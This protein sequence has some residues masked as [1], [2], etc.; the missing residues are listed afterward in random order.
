MK[1]V[2][3]DE[4]SRLEALSEKNGVTTAELMQKAGKS[5][6]S[7][8]KD[9]IE[10]N[11]FQKRVYLLVGKGNNGGDALV[12]GIELFSSGIEVVAIV[13]DANET[14]SQLASQAKTKFLQM[15]GKV[16]PLSL[17]RSH[18]PEGGIILDGIFGTGFH[19]AI[20]GAYQEMI[21]YANRSG[22]PILSIDIASGI[23]GEGDPIAASVTLSIGFPKSVSYVG[24]GWD[25]SGIIQN[26]PIFSESI[27]EEAT[28]V[29]SSVEKAELSHLLPHIKRSRHKYE[30][31]FVAV[32][33]GSP[34]M[35]GAAFLASLGAFKGGAGIVHLY[36]P[37]KLASA[38]FG[39]P[40]LI[41]KPLE[42]L[43]NLEK[44]GA[45]V[46]GPGLG[47]EEKTG[48][49]VEEVLSE[50]KKVVIDGDALFHVAE[51]RLLLPAGAILTPHQ[52]EL[53]RL[54]GG[55]YP[56]RSSEWFNVS[57]QF[58]SKRKITLL[59]KGGPT[60]LFGEEP[61]VIPFGDPGMATA[62]SG[63][64][65]SGMIGALLACGLVSSSAALLG[66]SLHGIAGELAAEKVSSYSM[67]VQDIADQ[68]PNVFLNLTKSV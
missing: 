6:A 55:D 10:A 19:G 15:G 17:M 61:R 25:Y 60:F 64:L 56:Q 62:G 57:A 48:D 23:G 46:I 38:F 9:F 63:D 45:I 42:S 39:L 33:A 32:I 5:V 58:A 12:A 30:R 43:D 49:L 35:T 13:A 54:L 24:N 52:G 34:G 47:R 27:E 11:G 29:F 4:M 44:Y 36:T 51:R 26:L 8:T 59:A 37:E 41:V 67:T 65:L 3:S 20:R 2:T 16:Y 68:V 22:M 7:F 66:A 31:G 50:A 28:A 18:I 21:D 40:E 1:V 53:N 14:H